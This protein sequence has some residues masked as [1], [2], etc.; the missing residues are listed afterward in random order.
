MSRLSSKPSPSL[1]A[2]VNDAHTNDSTLSVC[3]S[4]LYTPHLPPFV[5][6]SPTAVAYSMGQIINSVCLRHSVCLSVWTVDALCVCLS[7]L[8]Q[9]HFVIDF[10]QKWHRGNNPQ[11]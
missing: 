8:S 1:P 10:R 5:L 3:I 6:L 4:R 11:K 9:S 7:T 2:D